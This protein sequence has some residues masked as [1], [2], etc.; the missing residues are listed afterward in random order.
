MPCRLG[1]APPRELRGPASRRQTPEW[2]AVDFAGPAP[3]EDFSII[4]AIR[5]RPAVAIRA[6]S[7]IS[8]AAVG[9]CNGCVTIHAT[10]I[11]N[12]HRRIVQGIAVRVQRR[13]SVKVRSDYGLQHLPIRPR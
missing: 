6:H 9:F 3:S 12:R 11:R 7:E 10:A 1:P 4:L 13:P 8:L 2:A 5:S